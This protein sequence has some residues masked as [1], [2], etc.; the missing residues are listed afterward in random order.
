ML[1]SSQLGEVH[2]AVVTSVPALQD[3]ASL[4]CLCSDKTGTLT[5]AVI[6]I[7]PDSIAHSPDFEKS[8]VL[9]YAAASAN[10]DKLGDPIDS[11]IVRACPPPEGWTQERL[12]GFSPVTKRT[13]AFVTTN[14]G[15]QLVIAKGI[16]SKI[17]DTSAGGKDDAEVQWK[18]TNDATFCEKMKVEDEKLSK[19]GYK[20]IAIA[21]SSDGG[22]SFQFVGVLPMLDPPRDDTKKTIEFLHKANVSV[23]MI[24]GDHQNIA[25]ETAKLINLG[26]DIHAGQEVRDEE[27]DEVKDLILHAD[28]F[29]QV[30]PSDKRAVVQCLRHEHGMVVGM[31]G[32]GVN[33]APALSAA[34]VGIAVEG[35]TDAAKS[36]A[37]IILTDPGLSPI[38]GAIV[39]SREIFRKVK[40]YVV[41]RVAASI[42]LVTTLCTAI[43]IS[44]CSVD[45]VLIIL[46]AL[47]NDLSMLGIAHDRVAASRKPELP[48]V[49]EITIRAVFF[50]F[51][52]FAFAML[53]IYTVNPTADANSN[54][55]KGTDV[56]FFCSKQTSAMIW[57]YLTVLSEALVFS[58]RIPTGFCWQGKRPTIWLFIGVGATDVIVSLLAGV[59]KKMWMTDIL[60]TWAWAIASFFVIDALKVLVF[61]VICGQETGATITFDEFVAYEDEAIDDPEEH[62]AMMAERRASEKAKRMSIHKEHTLTPKEVSRESLFWVNR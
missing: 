41:Y 30:L 38:F 57:V 55:W 61:C 28:G 36:A 14:D 43:Y 44:A 1:R 16:L 7:I 26:T 56:E 33:D 24:T 4:V 45:S 17:L 31:T 58:V 20:T 39:S 50:G 53:F 34:Q 48:R 42:F 9:T 27:S 6:T 11:A 60:L 35:A 10:K 3:I 29:A 5:T 25:I 54:V 12:V 18:V 23:K 2:R 47:F 52:A 62:A 13:L 59:W 21:V 46:L 40:T 8:D 22:K 51:T 32:D 19:S 37:A 15:N 49:A